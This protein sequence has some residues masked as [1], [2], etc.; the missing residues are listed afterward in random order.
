[1]RSIYIG[2]VKSSIVY[3]YKLMFV[4]APALEAAAPAVFVVWLWDC[5]QI[6]SCNEAAIRPL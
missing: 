6:I 1:M 4:Y 3:V 2:Y 5:L